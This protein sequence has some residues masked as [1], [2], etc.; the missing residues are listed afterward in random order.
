MCPTKSTNTNSHN[1][2]TNN[3][4]SPT[5]PSN[6]II[7]IPQTLL[8]SLLYY[9]FHHPPTSRTLSHLKLLTIN[10]TSTTPQ[11]SDTRQL[12]IPTSVP[13]S[14]SISSQQNMPSTSGNPLSS[15]PSLVMQGQCTVL[16]SSTSKHLRSD[17]STHQKLPPFHLPMITRSK[18]NTHKPKKLFLYT[19]YTP[20]EPL[21]P[22]TITQALNIPEWRQAM[23]EEFDVLLRN[24]T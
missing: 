16:P 11:Q 17:S 24:G 3:I 23:F 18:N 4:I 1:P 12:S 19:K 21:E 20:P 2:P 7:F 8:Q 9:L 5:P 10:S 15:T 22:S 14:L 6:T 13:H